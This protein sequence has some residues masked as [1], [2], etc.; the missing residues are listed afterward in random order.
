MA[1]ASPIG[2]GVWNAHFS[3]RTREMGHPRFRPAARVKSYSFRQSGMPTL[4]K[5]RTGWG[6]LFF[7][8]CWGVEIVTT[9]SGRYS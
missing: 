2:F 9:C 3:Q 4:Y 1:F 5:E 7:L 8:T 6:T